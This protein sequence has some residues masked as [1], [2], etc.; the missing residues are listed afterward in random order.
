MRHLPLFRPVLALFFTALVCLAFAPAAWAYETYADWRSRHFT[1]SQ[2][3]SGISA[4]WSDANGDG[5]PNLL[6][7]AFGFSPWETPPAGLSG[8]GV[9]EDG[10]RLTFHFPRRRAPGDIRY[11]PEFS[12]D[13]AEWRTGADAFS[14]HARQAIDS[15]LELVTLRAQSPLSLDGRQFFRLRVA[16]IV[17][18]DFDGLDDAWEIAHFGDLSQG[19]YDDYDRDGI[20]NGDAQWSGLDP[21]QG[22]TNRDTVPPSWTE[23]ASLTVSDESASGFTLNWPAA[24]DNKPGTV[25]YIV[26]RNNQPLGPATSARTQSVVTTELEGVQRWH[27]RPVDL[28]GNVGA[29]SAVVERDLQPVVDAVFSPQARGVGGT[30]GIWGWQE[31]ETEEGQTPKWYS[32]RT[33]VLEHEKSY[34]FF[35]GTDVNISREETIERTVQSAIPMPGEESMAV[36]GSVNGSELVT[37]SGV[38]YIHN[39]TTGSWAGSGD[40]SGATEFLQPPEPTVLLTSYSLPSISGEPTYPTETTKI[41]QEHWEDPDFPEEYGHNRRTGS[42]TTTLSDEVTEERLIGALRAMLP[43][44]SEQTW[45]LQAPTASFY[46]SES[47]GQ[48]VSVSLSEAEYKLTLAVTEEGRRYR[49]RW[50]EVFYPRALPDQPPPP[51]VSR[52]YRQWVV[53]GTGEAV[54]SEIF[55]LPAPTEEGVVTLVAVGV[56][57]HAP[58]AVAV[59]E[60][61]DERVPDDESEWV[62]DAETPSPLRADGTVAMADLAPLWVS[63]HAVGELL[64]F[65]PETRSVKISLVQGGERL[66]LHALAP[67]GGGEEGAYRPEDWREIASGDEL[68]GSVYSRKDAEGNP[69]PAW[70]LI[71]EGLEPGKAVLRLDVDRYGE[72]LT[73]Q[74]TLYV[75][76]TELVARDPDDGETYVVG[77]LLDGTSARPTV[78]LRVV[79]ADMSPA[80]D[81]VIV[82]LEGEV[83]D[84]LSESLFDA[85]LRTWSL[86]FE[87]NGRAVDGI[88]DLPGISSSDPVEQPWLNARFAVEFTRTIRIPVRGPGV[89]MIRAVTSPNANGMRGWDEVAIIVGRSPDGSPSL[90]AGRMVWATAPSSSTVDTLRLRLD[91]VM[92]S[93]TDPELV[94]TAANSGLFYGEIIADGTS[95]AAILELAPLAVADGAPE[96]LGAL[97]TYASDTGPR[98][99]AARWQRGGS[100]FEFAISEVLVAPGVR[101]PLRVEAVHEGTATPGS[102]VLP[103][104]VRVDGLAEAPSD[105]PLTL[106][107]GAKDHLTSALSFSP[108]YFYVVGPERRGQ[109]TRFLVSLDDS[110]PL[111][112]GEALRA[113]PAGTG[114][115]VLRVGDRIVSDAQVTQV[116]IGNRQ[117]PDVTLP[118]PAKTLEEALHFYRLLYQRPAPGDGGVQ[119]GRVL[120]EAFES[121]NGLL[122]I[123]D[124]DEVE[125]APD[126]TGRLVI[127]IGEELDPLSAA[128]GI[129]EELVK[130]S[131]HPKLQGE[132]LLNGYAGDVFAAGRL[133]AVR[134][135]SHQLGAVVLELYKAAISI[136]NE[137]ADWA[138][139]IDEISQGN[140][141]AA[142]GFLPFVP[143]GAKYVIKKSGTQQVLAEFSSDTV[144]VVAG[145]MRAMKLDKGSS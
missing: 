92:P 129:F 49:V 102:A 35:I 125:G 47:N 138:V 71:V 90:Q 18:S 61:F 140:W 40:F 50:L 108:R 133:N 74:K 9:T 75:T 145:A 55:S 96:T 80:G 103:T 131:L 98:R 81:E 113:I 27:I 119:I 137:G 78:E 26:Y 20:I 23:G 68:W 51:P 39:I 100:A 117:L 107:D 69:L 134:A 22:N 136:L 48:A 25:R 76:R 122:E 123:G 58:L 2:L 77:G 41:I 112:A 14:L 87:V 106:S 13:L 59:N 84:P 142:I 139:A 12:F 126:G 33:E 83:F 120:L 124:G 144:A 45:G 63:S 30:Q 82:H 67:E 64:A 57:L 86:A 5:L 111:P 28:A 3:A 53:E 143:A 105:L 4:D 114:N 46:R 127:R 132:L 115:F 1:S 29:P 10:Q 11:Q 21:K 141:S 93:S 121:G 24:T 73:E 7:F 16:R 89:K 60:N 135:Q 31:F 101:V 91:G 97:L 130:L 70:S 85:R 88:T 8:A 128:Q 54:E 17:D 6:H 72:T 42:I 37:E 62:P 19:Y 95:R 52:G 32:T 65:G 79:S 109:P 44:I 56:A 118:K 110:I 66:R 116:R 15:D 43:P 34:L 104:V 36:S 99:L 94:E 38:V